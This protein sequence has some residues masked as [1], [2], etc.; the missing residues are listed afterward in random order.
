[1]FKHCVE[2]AFEISDKACDFSVVEFK[3]GM[4]V[5]ILLLLFICER[6]GDAGNGDLA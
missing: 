4:F 6:L 5:I 1:M 2:F 3:T